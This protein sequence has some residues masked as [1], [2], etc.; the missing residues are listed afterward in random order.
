MRRN[1]LLL[2]LVLFLPFPTKFVAEALDLTRSAE[3][4]AVIFYYDEATLIAAVWVA[5]ARAIARS[6]SA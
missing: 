2:M 1:I 3:R 6:S 4:A 5:W